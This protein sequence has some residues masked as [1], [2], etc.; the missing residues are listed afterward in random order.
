MR[1]FHTRQFTENFW[2]GNVFLK[3]D[4][5]LPC[6][7]HR[8][9]NRHRRTRHRHF[10]RCRHLHSHVHYD[11]NH[12][13]GHHC[14]CCHEGQWWT[15][16]STDFKLLVAD[17]IDL[18]IDC[19]L[20][21]E[22]LSSGLVVLICFVLLTCQSSSI[23]SSAVFHLCNWVSGFSFFN[24]KSRLNDR[25]QSPV[26][27]LTWPTSTI[28]SFPSEIFVIL[29]SG[30]CIGGVL[31]S[32]MITMSLMAYFCLLLCHFGRCWSVVK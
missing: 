28:W 24:G 4:C 23:E 2:R 19:S 5:C 15:I 18:N 22:R 8:R 13:C 31:S 9:R 29:T 3:I 26:L 25:T 16:S 10:C 27:V 12:H 6:C 20:S 17:D 21:R 1:P 11:D 30:H 32:L 7:H 14:R